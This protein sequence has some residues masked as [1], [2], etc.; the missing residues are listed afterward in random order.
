MIYDI[1]I[2]P[3]TDIRI[4]STSRTLSS[5]DLACPGTCMERC[6]RFRHSRRL[7][8]HSRDGKRDRIRGKVYEE[9]RSWRPEQSR[10]CI[11]SR[12]ALIGYVDAFSL[13]RGRKRKALTCGLV[14]ET[15]RWSRTCE[16]SFG[17]I[18]PGRS[19]DKRAVSASPARSNRLDL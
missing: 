18:R 7:R 19:K 11:V 1:A 14:P 2:R 3:C 10:A 17:I 8:G 15:V 13:L 4:Q 6:R 5:L 16:G 12:G 9:P